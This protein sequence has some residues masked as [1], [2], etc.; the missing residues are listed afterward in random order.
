MT[1]LPDAK[2]L[3]FYDELRDISS[4]AKITI[5]RKGWESKGFKAIKTKKIQC[6]G[7]LQQS[8]LS[9]A[10]GVLGINCD[11][12]IQAFT[13][14]NSEAQERS[15]K[16]KNKLRKAS[17]SIHPMNELESI[18]VCCRHFQLVEDLLLLIVKI[19]RSFMGDIVGV[20]IICSFV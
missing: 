13:H 7:Q 11:S 5:L 17:E 9:P 3:L 16:I 19:V 18:R 4:S 15:Y 6:H 8:M 1:S 14:N 10:E 20:S 2:D 12:E